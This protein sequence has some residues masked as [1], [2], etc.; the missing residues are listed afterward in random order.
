MGLQ[1]SAKPTIA[2]GEGIGHQIS[3]ISKLDLLQVMALSH[4]EN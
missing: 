4:N 2:V 3:H 1:T